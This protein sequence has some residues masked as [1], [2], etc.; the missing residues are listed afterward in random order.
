M[1]EIKTIMKKTH[2]GLSLKMMAGGSFFKGNTFYPTVYIKTQLEKK[3]E[4]K[5]AAE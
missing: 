3:A 2:L 5:M 4:E 1:I